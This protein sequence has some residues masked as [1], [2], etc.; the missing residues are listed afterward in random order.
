MLLI[1]LLFGNTCSLPYKYSAKVSSK[2]FVEQNVVERIF[3][4][5]HLEIEGEEGFRWAILN[6]RFFP[7]FF[8]VRGFVGEEKAVACLW[9]V[10][11]YPSWD[12]GEFYLYI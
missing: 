12:E 6:C 10:N 9:F 7:F 3:L 5:M 1:V 4:G 8:W 2:R 11:R